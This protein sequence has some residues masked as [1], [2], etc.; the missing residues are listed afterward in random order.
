MQGLQELLAGQF[1]ALRSD[2]IRP[3][4][5]PVAVDELV[6]EQHDV[7]VHPVLVREVDN[8][9]GVCVRQPPEK[10]DVKPT[11]PRSSIFDLCK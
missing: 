2:R 5:Q 3:A 7:R 10:G 8:S 1:Q 6:R 9:I 11:L 4:L